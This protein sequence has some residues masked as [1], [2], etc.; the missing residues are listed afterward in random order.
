M[1]IGGRRVND[2]A[3]RIEGFVKKG[4]ENRTDNFS[5]GNE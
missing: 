1:S 3:T 5:N 4:D 2:D